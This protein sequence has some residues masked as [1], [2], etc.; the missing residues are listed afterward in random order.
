MDI[1][2]LANANGPRIGS[3]LLTISHDEEFQVE[4][5]RAIISIGK[6]H[7]VSDLISLDMPAAILQKTIELCS[8]P[9]FE[10]ISS[11]ALL[12]LFSHDSEG[13]RKATAILAV[14]AFPS[15]RIKSILREYVSSE[16]D[17]YYNVIH[18]LDL[19]ASM[20]REVARSIARVQQID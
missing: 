10:K 5:A 8:E 1:T 20:S 14:R 18:W 15:K 9:R 6:K 13:V 17:R 19:G 3:T 11:D 12:T 7:S 16:K 2:V 4:V